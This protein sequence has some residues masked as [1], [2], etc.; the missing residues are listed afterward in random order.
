MIAVTTA[1]VFLPKEMSPLLGSFYMALVLAVVN[2]PS[3][4]VWT[5]FGTGMRRLLGSPRLRQAF[6]IGLALTLVLTGAAMLW[7]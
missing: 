7:E 2:Y 4:S 3:I 6:S 5:L 1:T